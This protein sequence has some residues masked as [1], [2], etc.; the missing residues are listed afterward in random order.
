MVLEVIF[1]YGLKGRPTDSGRLVDVCGVTIGA[2]GRM[3]IFNTAANTVQIHPT[4]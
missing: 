3:L 1:T 4:V 2:C